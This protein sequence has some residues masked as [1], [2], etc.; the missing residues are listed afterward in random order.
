MMTDEAS[1]NMSHN[2]APR[3][4]PRLDSRILIADGWR[5]YA[6]LDSG[7][8]HKLEQFGPHI[9][10]RP[11]PFA[12]WRPEGGDG[13]WQRAMGEFVGGDGEEEGR[14]HFARSRPEAW[15]MQ[16]HDI[17]FWGR[18]TP[19]RHLGFFP[20]QSVHWD[21]ARQAIEARCQKGGSANILNLFAYTGLAS[22]ICAKAGGKVTHV[23]ASAKAIQFAKENQILSGLQ[24]APIRWIVDDVMKFLAR[25]IRRGNR[26]DGV[27]LDPPKYGRGPKGEIWKLEDDLS[28]LLGACSDLLSDQPLFIA[29]TIYAVRASFL[30]LH[31]A[32]DG[33]LNGLHK[34]HTQSGEMALREKSADRLLPTA[35][36]ARWRADG[37]P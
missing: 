37:L 16:Y 3:L 11:E 14:W 17:S 32:L 29:A 35:I 12:W 23:D 1:K 21:F 30:S 28:A 13:L 15:P 25:E 34:G 10:I 20:E 26:Y 7:N 6:L 2:L 36:F 18:C 4:D 24:T 27:I 19:F 9:L 22:L 31:Q 33:A 8:G 5:D